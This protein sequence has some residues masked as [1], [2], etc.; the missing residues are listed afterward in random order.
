M[1]AGIKELTG[2]DAQT[3]ARALARKP[4]RV[5]LSRLKVVTPRTLEILV[6]G[7]RVETPDIDD[8][9]LVPDYGSG[10]SDDIVIPDGPP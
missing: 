3:V 8:L 10:V 9:T 7:G 6:A 1:L 5:K 2:P 4:G